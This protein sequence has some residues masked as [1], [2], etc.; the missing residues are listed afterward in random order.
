MEHFS[1]DRI[2]FMDCDPMGHLNN[3]RFI[4]YMLNAREIHIQQDYGFS[5]EEYAKKTGCVWIIVQNEIAYFQEVKF[6]EEVIISSK[7]IELNPRT[8]KVEI[9]M[10]DSKNEKNIAVLWTTIINFNLKTRRSEDANEELLQTY[11]KFLLPVEEKDFQS[12]ANFLR[13]QN[14]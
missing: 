2:R 10:K 1:K 8:S 13:M 7:I 3:A 5:S 6:Y 14:K 12:R 4:D 11:Q 9:L